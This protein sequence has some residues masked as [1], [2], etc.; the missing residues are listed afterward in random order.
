MDQRIIDLYGD[1]THRHLDR[2]LFMSRLIQLTGN[3]AAAAAVLPL[4]RPN[5]AKA[6]MVAEDDPRL[7]TEFIGHKG[8]S[9]EVR[10]YLA[11]PKGADRL[12]GVVVIH[13]NRGLNPHIQDVVRRMALEGYLALGSDGLSSVGGTP[14]DED[15]ARGM[16]RGLDM[17]VVTGDFVA[18]VTFLTEHANCTGNV[19]CIGFCWGGG[20]ANQLAVNSPNLAA[21]VVY[22]GRSPDSADVAKIKVPMLLHYGELDRFIN[23]GVPDF[24]AAL[25]ANGVKYSLHM[26]AGANHAFNNDTSEARYNEAAAKLAWQRTIDFFNE[27]L[28]G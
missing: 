7:D 23:P 28:K 4:I 19:G 10:A 22:Y 17:G 6:A 12:P 3:T 1:F 13:E 24:E 14:A 27:N 5:Y 16:F 9:G 21:A 2:R 20:M 18:G 15:A 26:Y 25:K 8:A 11:K